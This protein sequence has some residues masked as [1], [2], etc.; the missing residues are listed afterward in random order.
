MV[1]KWNLDAY[2]GMYTRIDN[3]NAGIVVRLE[4]GRLSLTI[5]ESVYVELYIVP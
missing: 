2:V 4:R 5:W 1:D 3:T